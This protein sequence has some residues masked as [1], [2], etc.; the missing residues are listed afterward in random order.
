MRRVGTA[1]HIVPLLA[2][3]WPGY[4]LR[5]R[6]GATHYHIHVRPGTSTAASVTLDGELLGNDA[7]ELLDDGTEHQVVVTCPVKAQ[8]PET[9]GWDR[10]VETDLER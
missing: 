5:Y 7:L 2:Q 10:T 6:Y 4:T 8:Q 1:L 9:P 3:G